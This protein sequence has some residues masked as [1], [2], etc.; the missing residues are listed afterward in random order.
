MTTLISLD[1]GLSSGVTIGTYSDTEPYQ[2]TH[3]FQIEDGLRGL[4]SIVDLSWN[5]SVSGRTVGVITIS[6]LEFLQEDVV[7][8]CEKF[9]PRPNPAGG[10]L[11]LKSAEPMLCEGFLV[12]SGVMPYYDH[13][14]KAKN[15]L[16]RA[17]RQQYFPGGKNLADRK[18][19]ARQWRI[20]HGL[21]LTGKD[22]GQKDADDANSAVMHALSW[23]REWHRPTQL[24]YFGGK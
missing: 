17:P 23:L 3:A 7:T 20:D 15:E 24:E 12:S 10:G 18:K 5:W 21:H 4:M 1:P 13:D 22:V 8:I 6:G 11:A 14:P 9:V 19:R 2:M 16:W